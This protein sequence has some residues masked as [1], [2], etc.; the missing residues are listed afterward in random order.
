M[1]KKTVQT[2][3][4]ITVSKEVKAFGFLKNKDTIAKIAEDISSQFLAL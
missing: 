1:A 2:V 3:D 4:L